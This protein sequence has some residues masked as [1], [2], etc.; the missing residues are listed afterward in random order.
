MSVN[1]T[2]TFNAAAEEEK[3]AD[4]VARVREA[5]RAVKEQEEIHARELREIIAHGDKPERQDSD[6]FSIIAGFIRF[7]FSELL[8][9]DNGPNQGVEGV[10]RPSFVERLG[11]GRAVVSSDAL[12]KW[13]A[14]QRGYSGSIDFQ[15]PIAASTVVTSG[16]GHRCSAGC[17]GDHK[18]LDLAPPGGK[19]NPDILAAAKGVVIFAGE[20]SGYGKMVIVGHADGSQT[21]YGHM[22]GAKMPKLGKEVAQG[23]V[24]GVMGTTGQSTG[25]HLHFEV[26]E[27]GR[28]VNP[29]IAG[30][31][32][33]KGE[34]LVA[35]TVAQPSA[36]TPV[37]VA[38]KDESG[39]DNVAKRLEVADVPAGSTPSPTPTIAIAKAQSTAVSPQAFQIS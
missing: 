39:P 2:I 35:G 29:K 28:A 22:T 6:I 14:L 15:S 34:S 10:R 23:E 13:A 12:P 16:F 8:A 26:R 27:N 24:I 9:P 36:E 31:A 1:P 5:E 38:A 3:E 25:V 37:A 19:S 21:L 18:G 4:R 17:S 33:K 20:Q 11:Q 30:R 7:L 32:M